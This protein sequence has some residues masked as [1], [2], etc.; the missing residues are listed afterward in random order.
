MQRKGKQEKI[1]IPKIKQV[2]ED[3]KFP[4]D[5]KIKEVKACEEK[6]IPNP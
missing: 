5:R 4:K 1:P 6:I 2:K 3:K